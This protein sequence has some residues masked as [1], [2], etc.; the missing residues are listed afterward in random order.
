VIGHKLLRVKARLV[1]PVEA[2]RDLGAFAVPA[3]LRD[4]PEASQPFLFESA[5]GTDPGLGALELFEVENPDS[6]TA[7]TPLTLRVEAHLEE[8]ERILPYAW[9]GEF[10]LPLGAGRQV[11]DSIE[12]DVRQL[13]VPRE[14]SRDIER[15]IFKS[16]RILFQKLAG[17]YLGAKYDY[18]LLAMVS[19]QLGGEPLYNAATEAVRAAVAKASRILLYVHGILG[20]TLGMTAS[21]RAE[22][23]LSGSPSHRI[24]DG[25]DVILAFDYENINTSIEST[26]RDLK[27]RLAVVGLSADHGK[28]LHV[29]AHSMGGL[30]SRWFIE[31]EGGSRVVQHLF[32][33]G[34]PHGGSPWPSIQNWANTALAIGL[35]G[36]GQISWTARLLGYLVRVIEKVDVALD[37]MVPSSPFLMELA[38]STDPGVPYTLLVGNTSIMPAAVESGK[39]RDLLARLAPQRVLRAAT[40]VAFLEA[41][42]DIAVSV[43][44]AQSI[45]PGRALSTGVEY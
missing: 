18:P 7:D 4:D 28:T 3:I 5:R 23:M 33:L 17:S 21:A 45:P 40:S 32:M 10:F 35:N 30:V 1:S 8:G 2:E 44:S 13:P 31:R 12:I 25:Y 11:G 15:G 16:V 26:A 29:I 14:T 9:D 20:D 41:P 24:G 39:L 6:V 27:Q 37:Q 34:T 43:V 36:L 19:F 42:N 22:V 38:R